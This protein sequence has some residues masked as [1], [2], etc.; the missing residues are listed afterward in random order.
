MSVGRHNPAPLT[1][2]SRSRSDDPRK[3]GDGAEWSK[4]MARSQDGDREAYRTLLDGVP[5]SDRLR[6]AVSNRRAT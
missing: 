4:L 5:T 2:I 6:R 3:A 1:I